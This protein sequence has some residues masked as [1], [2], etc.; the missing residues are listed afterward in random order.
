MSRDP[1]T[2]CSIYSSPL[3]QERY[4]NL[5]ENTKEMT[6]KEVFNS[7]TAEQQGAIRQELYKKDVPYTTVYFWLDGR[8]TP[9]TYFRQQVA[10]I[11]NQ[12]T[13]GHYTPAELWP[14]E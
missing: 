5:R 11:I 12:V 9:P 4:H 1:I 2:R 6:I 14:Q 8:R 13:D 10:D 3:I 7:A